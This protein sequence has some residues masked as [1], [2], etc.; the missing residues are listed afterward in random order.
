MHRGVAEPVQALI[1]TALEDKISQLA[2]PSELLALASEIDQLGMQLAHEITR[3]ASRP[4]L[5]APLGPVLVRVPSVYA[6]TL[7]RA[8]ERFDDLGSPKRSTYVLI[9]AL[10]KTF[11]PATINTVAQALRFVLEAHGQPA[12]AER[13]RELVTMLDERPSRRDARERFL[14]AIDELRDLVDWG[15]LDDELG[16]D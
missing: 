6:R 14:A 15:A 2:E 13:V 1:L 8:A 9:E 11:E 5:A 10:R 7:L 12:A 16:L 4:E 3:L